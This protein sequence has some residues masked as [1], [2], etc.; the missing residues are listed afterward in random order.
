MQASTSGR[1][2]RGHK[3]SVTAVALSSDDSTLFSVSKDGAILRTD[4]ESGQRWVAGR[5]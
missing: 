2:L 1:L 4:V 3:L 5:Q